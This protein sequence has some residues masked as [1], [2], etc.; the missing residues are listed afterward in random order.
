MKQ[1]NF[2]L[3]LLVRLSTKNPKFF[4]ILQVIALILGALSAALVYLVDQSQV[5]LPGFITWL[6]DSTVWVSSLVAL[7]LAQLPNPNPEKK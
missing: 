4:R 3:E 5:A 1:K 7:I 2:L 6:Q